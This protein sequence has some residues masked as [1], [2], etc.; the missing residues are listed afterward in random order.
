M[1]DAFHSRVNAYIE[2]LNKRKRAKYVINTET[3]K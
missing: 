2:A 1:K 3:Y